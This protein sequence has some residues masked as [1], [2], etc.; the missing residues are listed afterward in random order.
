ME[1]GVAASSHDSVYDRKSKVINKAI[2]DIGMG[3][4]Q[5]KLFILSGFG[6][7]ADNL[8]LQDAALTLPSLSAEYGITESN[9]R[10]T[11]RALFTGLCCGAVFWGVMS[12]ILGRRP[13]INLT[14]F[15]TSVFEI[16]VGG[17]STWF[18]ARALFAVLVS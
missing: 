12:D 9:V 13:A 5:W 11:T 1:A 16:A 17:S 6:W 4:Y 15:G 10:Y 18:Q 7:L 14:L 3:R 8:W 2:Q